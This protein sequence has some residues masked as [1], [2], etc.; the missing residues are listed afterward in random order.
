VN[1]IESKPELGLDK[2]TEAKV[3]VKLVKGLL[4]KA[5]HVV[6]SNPL[7]PQTGIDI[8]STNTSASASGFESFVDAPNTSSGFPGWLALSRLHE[9]L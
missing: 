1:E 8:V 7:L 4:R 6:G 3:H 5:A 9:S 2:E